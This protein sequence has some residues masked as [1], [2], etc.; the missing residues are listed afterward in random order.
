MHHG[1]FRRDWQ[2]SNAHVIVPQDQASWKVKLTGGRHIL[3]RNQC[4]C[5]G[6]IAS[7]K[8]GQEQGGAPAPAAAR[9][10]GTSPLR[11]PWRRSHPPPPPTC[12]RQGTHKLCCLKAATCAKATVQHM[13][14]GMTCHSHVTGVLW[15]SDHGMMP[16]YAVLAA[17]PVHALRHAARRRGGLPFQR[18]I[19]G[20]DAVAPPQ[21]PADAPVPDVLQPPATRRGR[22][23]VINHAWIGCPAFAASPFWNDCM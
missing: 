15:A 8:L 3:N 4:T 2:Q 13:R 6:S 22:H 20:R 5:A 23:A 11:P 18:H 1:L 9:A 16:D 21:L 14:V 12:H 19:P 10:R 17:P 7:K